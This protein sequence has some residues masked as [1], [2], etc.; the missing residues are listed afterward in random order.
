MICIKTG[1]T[2]N[3]HMVVQSLY[4]FHKKK[5]KNN[6]LMI[7]T[8]DGRYIQNNNTTLHCQKDGETVQL[9]ATQVAEY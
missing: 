6:S 3:T 4:I 8:V 1:R 9:I 5:N 2:R 7:T